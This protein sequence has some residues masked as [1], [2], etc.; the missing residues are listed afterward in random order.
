MLQWSM[1]GDT[2]SNQNFIQPRFFN[3]PM[4]RFV[5]ISGR[6]FDCLY[7]ETVKRGVTYLH[8]HSRKGHTTAAYSSWNCMMTRC[9]CTTHNSY[10][11]YGG[12]GI[13]V[14]KRWHYFKNFFRDMGPRPV[15]K[16]LDRKNVDGN[17]E[18]SNCRWASKTEQRANQRMRTK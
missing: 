17:Y 4:G 6:V 10:R 14:C 5:D 11:Y 1:G 3:T 7:R 9:Y 13:R 2:V 18:P 12:R 8:G 15:G 16:T